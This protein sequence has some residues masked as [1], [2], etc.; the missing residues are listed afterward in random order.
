MRRV[1]IELGIDMLSF[2]GDDA[3]VLPCCGNFG[4]RVVRY[5][6]SSSQRCRICPGGAGRPALTNPSG[7]WGDKT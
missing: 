1:G 5:E 2:D 4:R 6:S 7:V 3:A